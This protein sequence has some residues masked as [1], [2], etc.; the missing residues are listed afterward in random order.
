M[1]VTEEGYDKMLMADFVARHTILK[2]LAESNM[3]GTHVVTTNSTAPG[4]AAYQRSHSPQVINVLAS[5]R[6]VVSGPGGPAVVRL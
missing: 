4:G 5:S 1:P 3:L 6:Y 2:S